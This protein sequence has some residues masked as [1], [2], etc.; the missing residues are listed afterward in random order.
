MGGYDGSI[1]YESSGKL[2]ETN[3]EHLLLRTQADNTRYELGLFDQCLSVQ[4]EGGSFNG[5]YCSAFFETAPIL[6]DDEIDDEGI[7]KEPKLKRVTPPKHY[8]DSLPSKD[9]LVS[10]CLPSTC[11]ASDLGSALGQWVGR[12]P[13][14]PGN[15]MS[16]VT[17]TDDRYCFTREKIDA[18]S[19]PDRP[20]IA[21][22]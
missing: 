10:F 9:G 13:I 5:Q 19:V 21:V 11:T 20:T 14:G 8:F 6:S 3:H 7:L 1:V 22:M 4:A 17:I 2:P 12:T 18:Q 15:N 16:I